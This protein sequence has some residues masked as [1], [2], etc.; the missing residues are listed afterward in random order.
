M[1]LIALDLG[2]EGLVG[3]ETK[4]SSV[5]YCC[6]GG[7]GPCEFSS[8]V[9]VLGGRRYVFI[10]LGNKYYLGFNLHLHLLSGFCVKNYFLVPRIYSQLLVECFQVSICSG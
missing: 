6:L 7:V 10:R 3:R 4:T 1:C 8:K 2:P 9:L 5:V